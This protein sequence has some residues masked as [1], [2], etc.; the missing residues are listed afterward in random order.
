MS[1][2]SA[3][4]SHRWLP[5]ES[6]VVLSH[7]VF[8]QRG[9]PGG[10]PVNYGAWQVD[11]RVA[12]AANG[13]LLV[14]TMLM[15]PPQAIMIRSRD[16][17]RT[18]TEPT[19]IWRNDEAGRYNAYVYGFRRLRAGRLVAIIHQQH[20]NWLDGPNP[21]RS[22]YSDDDGRS[23]QVSARLAI[24]APFVTGSV[25]T[26]FF[27]DGDGTLVLPFE[28]PVAECG[29]L[30]TAEW[31]KTAFAVGFLRSRDRGE[32]W[33]HGSIAIRSHQA[34]G[35]YPTEHAVLPLANGNWLMLFYARWSG[36]PGLE[37]ACA[38]SI[39]SDQG[40]TWSTP[41]IVWT[42]RANHGLLQLP[43]GGI[44]HHAMSDGVLKYWVSY[45][46]GISWAYEQL[47][48]S[49]GDVAPS[50]V[51]IDDRTVFLLHSTPTGS[52]A[53][54]GYWNSGLRGQWLRRR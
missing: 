32:T 3:I 35:F 14:L 17:G 53:I 52:A 28:G 18:W 4:P 43:D 8:N 25:P 42:L 51:M 34:T 9:V 36:R 24:T 39:S 50:S 6:V 54:P 23:W 44:I 22:I 2:T 11:G 27:E 1:R 19:A 16:G 47:L 5:A 10:R 46:E 40:R 30:S 41:A 7:E 38:R 37:G 29:R 48:E 13:D 31:M 49:G 15:Q 20:P 45:D 26:Q 33:Q 21:T 12:R